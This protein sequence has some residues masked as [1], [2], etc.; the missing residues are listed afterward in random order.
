MTAP[1]ANPLLRDHAATLAFWILRLW[2]GLRALITGLEKFSGSTVEHAPLLDEFGQPDISGAMVEVTHKTYGWAHYHGLPP[3]LAQKFAA[4]PLLPEWS[5]SL[6]DRLLGPA[7]VLTGLTLLFGVAPR[8]TLFAQ[9]IL[10]VL[11]TVGLILINENAGIAWLG[12]H[13]LLVV[14]ALRLVEH[15][16]FS[17]LSRW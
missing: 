12:M 7:L 4:E 14:A 13:V 6:F 11:L 1:S 3:A 2:L 17:L 10:Y 9:G 5:L 15:D 8:L 16:R